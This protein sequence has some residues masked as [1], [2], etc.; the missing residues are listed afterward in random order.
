M[1]AVQSNWTQQH[2]A[3]PHVGVQQPQQLVLGQL[4]GMQPSNMAQLQQQQPPMSAA[5]V[6][7]HLQQQQQPQ[8]HQPA[9]APLQQA[10]QFSCSAE[11]IS[12]PPLMFPHSAAPVTT[13]YYSLQQQPVY[14]SQAGAGWPLALHAGAQPLQRANAELLAGSSGGSCSSSIAG[15][16]S[17]VVR[18]PGTGMLAV[19]A[20][21]SDM[22]QQQMQMHGEAIFVQSG[23]GLMKCA[24]GVTDGSTG[25]FSLAPG[26]LPAAQVQQPQLP[27]AWAPQLAEGSCALAAHVSLAQGKAPAA[28]AVSTSMPLLQPWGKHTFHFAGGM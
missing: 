27:V 7:L 16:S 4:V 18:L 20:P 19:S 1:R 12:A 5:A 2:S 9:S 3:E 23:G 17:S 15:S 8:L 26:M 25:H 14:T 24:S 21:G 10:R 11:V 28:A 13:P 22:Q 6:Q